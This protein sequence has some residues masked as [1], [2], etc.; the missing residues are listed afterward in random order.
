MQD[1]RVH[2]LVQ[3][4]PQR[5]TT[6]SR[7]GT[8]GKRHF[9]QESARTG[10]PPSSGQKAPSTVSCAPSRPSGALPRGRRSPLHPARRM[11]ASESIEKAPEACQRVH[12]RQ[13]EGWGRVEILRFFEVGVFVFR[14]VGGVEATM[15][16]LTA[17]K[18]SVGKASNSQN[19]LLWIWE[20][21]PARWNAR[22]REREM[23]RAGLSGGRGSRPGAC[24]H[25]R[26]SGAHRTIG[27]CT[28]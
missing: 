12:Q 20:G 6:A 11:E 13:G 3:W 4:L 2:V 21:Q 10:R 18:N 27:V 25:A 8:S 23:A 5:T 26:P 24:G 7:R 22:R 16:E 17:S 19:R 1:H 15:S 28:R 14:R 9:A